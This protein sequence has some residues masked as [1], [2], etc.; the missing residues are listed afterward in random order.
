MTLIEAIH[1]AIKTGKPQCV[2]RLEVRALD[3]GTVIEIFDANNGDTVEI[4]TID[5]GLTGVS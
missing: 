1:K 2:A 4:P 3:D 5:I